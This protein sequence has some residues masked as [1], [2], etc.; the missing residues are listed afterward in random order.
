MCGVKTHIVT[1]V[2]IKDKDASDPPQ[3]P[4]LVEMTA[5][6]FDLQEVCADRAYASIKNYSVIAEH[7]ATPYIAF[8][9]NHTGTGK[10]RSG[11]MNSGRPTMAA[12]VSYV[13]FL[14]R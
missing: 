3:L 7:G 6:N 11:R 10:G 13:S 4:K 8:K 1:A 9:S 14:Q 2:V 12:D 5:K